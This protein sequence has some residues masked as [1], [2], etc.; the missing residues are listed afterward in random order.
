LNFAFKSLNSNATPAY[1]A[2]G[3]SLKLPKEEVMEE[4]KIRQDSKKFFRKYSGS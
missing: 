3:Y 2:R 4:K 1:Q